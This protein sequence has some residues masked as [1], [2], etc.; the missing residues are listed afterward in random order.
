MIELAQLLLILLQAV[1]SPAESPA[2]PVEQ[3]QKQEQEQEQES[4]P[5]PTPTPTPEE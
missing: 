2:T 1:H 3:E 4:T 5:T